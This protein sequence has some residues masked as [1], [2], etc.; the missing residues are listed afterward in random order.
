MCP[1]ALFDFYD[2]LSIFI[3][4]PLV[5]VNIWLLVFVFFLFT[6]AFFIPTTGKRLYTHF[7]RTLATFGRDLIKAN[8]FLISIIICTAC[9]PGY[10]RVISIVKILRI[11]KT[12]VPGS[13][14]TKAMQ[15]F[16]QGSTYCKWSESVNRSGCL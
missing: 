11:V 15:V 16:A 8:I 4:Y 13:D 3:T 5:F 10:V 12:K 6:V 9:L 14:F 7:V 2:C 1:C